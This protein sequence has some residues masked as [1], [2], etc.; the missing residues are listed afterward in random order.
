[1]LEPDRDRFVGIIGDEQVGLFA[2]AGNRAGQ[3]LGARAALGIEFPEVGDGLL[4]DLATDPDGADE[5]PVPVDLAVLPARR[6]TQV[7][8]PAY[9]AWRPTKST[10]LVATTR[11]FQDC[12][13]DGGERY[14]RRGGAG[15]AVRLLNCGSWARGGTIRVLAVFRIA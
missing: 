1:V 7:Y 5:L 8:C 12:A 9:R 6:V 13:A 3:G 11:R 10:N 4:D 14:E 15:R 2:L